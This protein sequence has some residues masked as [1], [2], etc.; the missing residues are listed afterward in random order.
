VAWF[1]DWLSTHNLTT[2]RLLIFG[3][4]LVILMLVRPGGLFPSAQRA[5]EMQGDDDGD[6]NEDLYDVREGDHQFAGGNV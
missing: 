2:D 6:D 1:G 4:A 5:A 3:L